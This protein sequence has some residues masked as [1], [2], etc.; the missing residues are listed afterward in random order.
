[1]KKS[2][3]LVLAAV[4]LLGCSK[5]EINEVND[6]V[7]IA[8]RS[9]IVSASGQLTR[10]PFEGALS[11]DNV[12]EARVVTS[13]TENFSGAAYANGVMKFN[14]A[15]LA[16]NYETDGLEGTSTFQG[17]TPVYVYGLYPKGWTVATP[18]ASAEFTFNGSD[19][20]M[21][22][23]KV[24][25]SKADV[26]DAAYKTLSF[27]H[28]L[29]RLEVKLSA[30]TAAIPLLG[31][32]SAIRLIGDA[33]GTAAVNN[34]VVVS[35]TGASP[36]PTFSSAS[37][38]SLNFYGLTYNATADTKAYVNTVVP[39]YTLTTDP[40]F[41]GYS[42][43]APVT[44]TVAS[45]E[46]YFLEVVTAVGGSKKFAVDLLDKSSAPFDGST[47]G[48]SFVLAIHFVSPTHIAV[49]ATVEDWDEQGEWAG[50]VPI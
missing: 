33:A 9:D 44:A 28:L 34:K 27:K 3:L 14:N 47:A 49:T 37:A 21:A 46:E 11:A 20:V 39:S 50:E 24:S 6:D 32:V 43:V 41:V 16:A 17:A 22:A 31:N 18:A 36:V 13:A 10:A 42:L 26:D 2:Y 23:A 48:K 19:D 35:N 45:E 25:T 1:M 15:T 4:V 30:G 7:Q 29:T 8:L 40:T 12:L 5:S 38:T